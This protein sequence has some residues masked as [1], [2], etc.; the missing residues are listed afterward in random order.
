[1]NFSAFPSSLTN[2][3][4][5]EMSDMLLRSHLNTLWIYLSFEHLIYA[6]KISTVPIIFVWLVLPFP[7]HACFDVRVGTF[8]NAQRMRTYTYH[9]RRARARPARV[10]SRVVPGF[11][12][13]SKRLNYESFRSK[14]ITFTI[15]E[16]D[17][18]SKRI[19]RR[20]LDCPNVIPECLLGYKE[21]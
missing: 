4:S 10:N 13:A 3:Y 11:S 19:R 14:W 9:E 6:K 12:N 7:C 2:E 21:E 5:P 1:M 17:G 15:L 16:D 20:E 18:T 8:L